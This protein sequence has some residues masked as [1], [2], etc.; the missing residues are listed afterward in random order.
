MKKSLKV[1]VLVSTMF[2][3][4]GV[5]AQSNSGAGVSGKSTGSDVLKPSPSSESAP[6]QTNTTSTKTRS[7]VKNEM[8]NDKMKGTAAERTASD[9]AYPKTTGHSSSSGKSRADVK[10]EMKNDKNKGT[11][12]ER[13]A[14]DSAY[15][16]TNDSNSMNAPANK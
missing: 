4:A 14:S 3:S 11:A 7:E 5:M 1:A 16:K 13:S 8:K 2:L 9:S 12:A 10:Q 15:P 6:P